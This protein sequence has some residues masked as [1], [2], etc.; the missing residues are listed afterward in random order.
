[1]RALTGRLLELLRGLDEA[2][3]SRPTALVG[4][5]VKDLV[6][7]LLHGS[8]RRVTMLRDRYRGPMPEIRSNDDLIAFIQA[9]NRRFMDGMR[10]VSPQI[11][12]ESIE[13]Y[14]LLMI[15]QFE[16][17]D[18]DAPGLPVS[19]AGDDASPHWFDVAREYTEKWH[20]QQQVRDAVGADGLYD[21][22]LFE[23]LME[24]FARG[25]GHALRDVA[26]DDGE[27]V[28]VAL[29]GATTQ[30]WI[31]RHEAGT[32]ALFED[33]GGSVGRSV[34][35]P[36]EEVWKPWT[37]SAAPASVRDAL[38]GDARIADAIAR[39]IVVMAPRPA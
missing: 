14:D 38:H 3:W 5:S 12:I 17:T 33:D 15:E 24:T 7:H 6:A 23:P 25:S 34:G 36:A 18:A 32:W 16:S 31:L 20:H 19:W 39:M 11:L 8:V 30:S 28:R 9:D 4:R 1:M 27:R 21:A 13:R 35:A 37:C 22:A 2:Q 26:G 29:F 10:G